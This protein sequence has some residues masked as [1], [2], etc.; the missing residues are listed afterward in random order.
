VASKYNTRPKRT[1]IT[2]GFGGRTQSSGSGV[3][4]RGNVGRPYGSNII[5]VS[6]MDAKKYQYVVQFDGPKM[7]QWTLVIWNKIGPDGLVD[8]WFGHAC[9]TFTLAPGETLYIAF[10]EDS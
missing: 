8:G 9:K 1:Y 10:A 5:E 3:S 6:S 4:Y 2:T 7:G